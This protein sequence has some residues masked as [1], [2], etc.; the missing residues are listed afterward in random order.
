[1][2]PS[3][4]GLIIERAPEARLNPR[5]RFLEARVNCPVLWAVVATFD[6]G[7]FHI[8]YEAAIRADFG[9]T[10]LAADKGCKQDPVAA[11]AAALKKSHGTLLLWVDKPIHWVSRL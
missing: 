1:M 9:V 2:G 5:K 3:S 10:I 8:F 7:S 4:F 11:W 6:A